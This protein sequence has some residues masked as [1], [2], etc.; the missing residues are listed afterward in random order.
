M[1]L[2]TLDKVF[3][4]GGNDW[5]AKWLGSIEGPFTGEVTFDVE[6]DNGM[7]LEIDGKRVINAWRKKDARQGKISM[8]KGKK[9]P[10]VM[11]Y[12]KEGG[13]SYLKL[14]WSWEG[15][16]KEIVPT[17]ALSYTIE[18]AMATNEGEDDARITFP[19]VITLDFAWYRAQCR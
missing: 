18:D 3:T 17:D 14:Y 12:Y 19:A 5:G 4:D 7:R 2:D 9:Y 16:E 11:S 8:V 1:N 10:L 13:A 6:V 15:K